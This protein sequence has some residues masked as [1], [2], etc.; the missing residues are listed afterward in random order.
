MV[1]DHNYGILF[2]RNISTSCYLL[3]CKQYYSMDYLDYSIP[4][5]DKFGPVIYFLVK[6]FNTLNIDGT[7]FICYS[8]HRKYFVR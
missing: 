3:V 8:K 2:N 6:R 1:L 7:M 4:F 5:E